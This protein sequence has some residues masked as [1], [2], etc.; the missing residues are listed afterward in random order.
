MEK[1][2]DLNGKDLLAC[3]VAISGVSGGSIGNAVYAAINHEQLPERRKAI[4]DSVGLGNFLTVDLAYMFGHDMFANLMGTW[5]F[6]K[7][8]RAY[9]SMK[10]YQDMVLAGT[11]FQGTNKL[12]NTSFRG[13]WQE[14]N[15]DKNYPVLLINSSGKNSRKGV[16]ASL[17]FSEAEFKA[18][19]KNTDDILSLANNQTLSYLEA[20]STSNRFPV[21]SPAAKIP[22]KG[23]YVDGGYFENSGM[24]SLMEFYEFLLKDKLLEGKKIV[25]IQISNSGGVSLHNLTKDLV[26]DKEIKESSELGAVINTK[27]SL[28][29]LPYYYSDFSEIQGDT[30]KIVRIDMPHF[31]TDEKLKAFFDSKLVPQSSRLDSLIKTNNESIKK[32]RSQNPFNYLEPPLSRLLS[33]QSLNYM[34]DCILI[35]NSFNQLK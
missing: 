26:L 17:K 13:Y 19:F 18:C 34:K 30:L 25:F 21:L 15:R 29:F 2:R 11:D 7:G 23:H 31:Y 28:D 6:G 9:R 1:C 12:L 33:R 27:L 32:I 24:Q 16:A 3:T 14:M 35:D 22:G 5:L 4:I 20:T 8:D 10:S